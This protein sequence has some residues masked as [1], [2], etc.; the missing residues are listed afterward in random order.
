MDVLTLEDLKNVRGLFFAAE[1]EHGG[2]GE[3][4]TGE[5]KSTTR[6]EKDKG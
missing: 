5:A 3:V 4:E 6:E 2:G 1:I